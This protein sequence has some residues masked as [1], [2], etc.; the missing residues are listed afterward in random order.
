MKKLLAAAAVAAMLISCNNKNDKG[1]FILSGELKALPDQKI[2]LEQL[3]FSA[4]QP[5]VLD[6]ADVKAGKFTL[7]AIAPE[8][9]LFRIRTA[10]GAST[11]FINEDSKITFSGTAVSQ[12]PL[13]G[14]FSGRSGKSYFT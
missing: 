13:N 11:I 8:E 1:L 5:E 10:E 4:K 6:T 9:G 7:S 3:Y 2:Y 14:S 12:E